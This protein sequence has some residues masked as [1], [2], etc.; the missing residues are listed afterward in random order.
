MDGTLKQIIFM[1]KTGYNDSVRKF[2]STG[3]HATTL[4]YN[5]EG[6]IDSIAW[7]FRSGK[8]RGIENI[9]RFDTVPC[10]WD[11]GLTVEECEMTVAT[12][13]EIDYYANGRKQ[14]EGDYSKGKKD[15]VWNYFDSLGNMKNVDTL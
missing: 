13:H 9:F 2:D 4:Y 10:N 5:N 11:T 1:N 6:I 3:V 14:A 15:G 12:G 8:C 7:Y